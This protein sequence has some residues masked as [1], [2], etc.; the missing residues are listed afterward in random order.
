MLRECKLYSAVLRDTDCCFSLL[1]PSGRRAAPSSPSA[2]AFL[3]SHYPSSS[4]QAAVFSPLDDAPIFIKP[5]PLHDDDMGAQFPGIGCKTLAATHRKHYK[6]YA[7]QTQSPRESLQC[8][9]LLLQKERALVE[10]RV[11]MKSPQ[12]WEHI[13]RIREYADKGALRTVSE[14]RHSAVK[15]IDPCGLRNERG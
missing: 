2:V 5:E 9:L 4:V 3:R 7:R 13:T 15:I 11:A 1:Q 14:W 10:D 8:K 6:P 12:A